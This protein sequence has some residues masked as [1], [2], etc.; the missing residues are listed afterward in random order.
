MNILALAECSRNHELLFVISLTHA[1]TVSVRKSAVMVL[2]TRATLGSN[3]PPI[4]CHPYFQLKHT[5]SDYHLC[6]MKFAACSDNVCIA[7]VIVYMCIMKFTM[8]VG[9]KIF[10][11]IPLTI[12]LIFICFQLKHTMSS[13][14]ARESLAWMRGTAAFWC[15]YF[16][17]A[18]ESS[19]SHYTLTSSCP[20]ESFG[21]CLLA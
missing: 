5:E 21:E 19:L 8:L 6:M 1:P 15:M 12:S 18:W 2:F 11:L 17:T 9:T 3:E 20:T 13:T 10:N 4:T 7:Y 16:F 14:M